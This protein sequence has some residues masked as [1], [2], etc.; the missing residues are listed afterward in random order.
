MTKAIARNAKENQSSPSTR[1]EFMTEC[2]ECPVRSKEADD[3]AVHLMDRHGM[4]YEHALLWLRDK[5]EE[6]CA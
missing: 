3:I 5:V 4:D 1:G 2:P 6:A